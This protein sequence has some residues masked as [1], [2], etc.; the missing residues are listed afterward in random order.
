MANNATFNETE[1]KM[2]KAVDILHDELKTVRSG[3]ASTGV[4]NTNEKNFHI[5]CC[6]QIDK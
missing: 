1:S 6:L 2:K 5:A 3:R 4:S